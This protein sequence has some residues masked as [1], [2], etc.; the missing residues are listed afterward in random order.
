V[1]IPQY[2]FTLNLIESVDYQHLAGYPWID[3]DFEKELP[4]ALEPMAQEDIQNS[5]CILM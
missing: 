4:M 5:L 1:C 2:L 3:N